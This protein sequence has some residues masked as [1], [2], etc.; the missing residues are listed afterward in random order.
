MNPRPIASHFRRQASWKLPNSRAIITLGILTTLSLPAQ[1]LR[2]A[3]ANFP[4]LRVGAAIKSTSLTSGNAIYANTVRHDFNS[5]SPENDTKWGTLRPNQTPFEW[6][7]ADAIATF[8]RAAGQQMRGHTMQWYKSNPAWLTEGGFTTTQLRDILFDHIDQVGGHYRGDVFAW[9]VVNEAFNDN[10][11][12][13]DGFW[14]ND[15]GIGYAGNGT[16]YIEETFIRAAAADPDTKLI[17]NDYGAEVTNSKSNAIYAMAQDFLTRG[18]PLD[19]IGFQMHISGINYTTLRNNF[20][21]FNDL[22]L[23][24]HITEMD[25]RVPVDANGDATPASLESQ[26]EIYWNVLG[27]ALG[28]PRFTNFQTWGLHDG[29]SWIPGWEPGS[30][31][32]LLFD[33]YYQRKPAY[34]AVWNALANQAEKFPVLDYS[35]GDSTEVQAQDTLNAGAGRKLFSNSA[36]DFMTLS[37]AVPFAGEWNVKLGYRKSSGSGQFQ[38]AVAPEG[39]GSF[40]DLGGVVDCYDPSTTTGVTD[41]GNHTFPS[42]GNWQLRFT[43]TGK[44]ASA[45]GYNHTIDTVRITPISTGTN[46]PPTVSNVTDKTTNENVSSGPFAFTIGDAQ[47]AAPALTVQAVSLNTDLLPTANITIGGSGANRT[48]TLTPAANQFGSAAV[49]LLVSDGFHTTPETFILNVTEVDDNPNWTRT[50]SGTQQWGT[51]SNWVPASVPVSGSETQIRVL[52]GISLSS[53]TV[54]VNNGLAGT[55]SLSALTLGGTGVSGAASGVTLS[56]SPLSLAT[57]PGTGAPPRIKLAAN[58]SAAANSSLVYSVANDITLANTTSLTGIGNAD[59][60]LAGIL[61]GPGGLT[62]S[63]TGLLKLT[64]ANTYAGATA[65]TAGTLQVGNNTAA[66]TLG[67]GPVTNNATLRFHRSDNTHVVPNSISGAGQL[68]FG[69]STGPAGAITEL[70]GANT[71]TGGV[72]VHSGGLRIRDSGAL[73]TGAKLIYLTGINNF[74]S[75]LILNGSSGDINLPASVSFKTSNNDATQSAIIN[76]AGNNSIAGD[77]TLTDGGGVTA[78][79]VQGGTLTLSGTFRPNTATRSLDLIGPGNGTFSGALQNDGGFVPALRKSGSG[80]WT[81]TGAAHDFTGTTTVSGGT[82]LVQSP[83]ALPAGSTVTVNNGCTLGGNGTVGGAVNLLAGAILA[84]GGISSI[85]TLALSNLGNSLSLNGN[86]LPFEISTVGNSDRINLTG[87]LVLNGANTIALSLP[88]G[89]T[90][91]GTYTLM[92]YPAR[93]GSGTLELFTSYP[94]VTLTVGANNMTLTVTSP[95]STWKGNLSGVWDTGTQNW[96]KNGNPSTYAA[97]DAV[98]FND[99]AAGNFTVSGSASPVSVTVDN[100]LNDYIISADIGGPGTSLNK[101]GAGYLTLSGTNTY[102]GTTLV[103]TGTLLVQSPGSL[104]A[105]SAVTVNNG[106]SLGGDGTINGPVT[107]QSGSTVTPGDSATVGTLALADTGAAALTLNDNPLVFDISSAVSYDRITIT[108]GL[109]LNGAGTIIVNLPGSPPPFGTYTLMTYAAITGSGTLTL[110][111]S[112]PNVTFEVGPTSVTFTVVPREATW[113]GNVDGAWDIGTPNWLKGGVTSSYAAGDIVIFDDTATGNFTVAGH[114]SPSSVTV[115][116]TANHYALTGNIG[117][118]GT[119]LTKS[120]SGM[121]TLSGANSYTGTT[122]LSGGTLEVGPV[123]NDS[124]GSGGLYFSGGVLQGNGSFTRALSGNATPGPGQTAGATGGFAAKGGQLTLNLGPTLSLN[125][126]LFRF[127]TNFIFGTATA[128]SL[129]KLTSNIDFGGGNRNITVNSGAGGDAAEFSGVVSNGGAVG[130]AFIKSGTGLLILSGDNT[131][132]GMTNIIAGTLRAAH[133][134]AFGTGSVLLGNSDATLELA[135]GITIN[136][137]LTVSNT[138]NKKSISLQNGATTGDYAGPILISETTSANFELTS[139]TGQTLTV[140]GKISGTAGAAVSKTGPGTL[141]LSGENDH[142]T[143]TIISGGV[144]IATTLADA[145][146]P[147][148]IGSASDISG[149]L[150]INGATLRHDAANIATTNRKFAVGLDGATIDS[151]AVASTDI[152]NFSTPF[153]MGFSSQ[154]GARTLTLTGSNPG[155]NTI[156]MDINDDASGNPTSLV[157]D[158]AGKW[159]ITGASNDYTGDTTVHAGTLVLADNAGLKFIITDSAANKITG[160]GTVILDGD[161]TLNTTAVTTTNGSWTLVDAGTLEEN[162]GSTFSIVGWTQAADV[163]TR[164][165]GA[166]TWKFSEATGVLELSVTGA[167]PYLSWI[168]T[169]TS[170]TVADRDPE[171]DPD[172]DGTPNLLEFALN[173]N[174][175]DILDNGLIASL[176][177]DSGGPSTNELTLI[178]AVRDGALFNAGSATVSGINYTIEGSL[179]LAFPSAAVSTTGPSDTAPATTG[180]PS[181]AGSDWEYHTFKLDASEGL[182]GRGFLRLKV[183]QP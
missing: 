48:V 137:P 75:R 157:K 106:A 140:S 84:P 173:G 3:A 83:G 57:Q 158:G 13:R 64:G 36:A 91:P 66:A 154:L 134:N 117:G 123:A 125:A 49:L 174:P 138:G 146:S 108:G 29:D 169:F 180:L 56:G 131:N 12:L 124:L 171:D 60:T 1:T 8:N 46:T 136:R 54:T 120:G 148:S 69:A 20:K 6:T 150:V 155:E 47:T 139:S 98:I 132:S 14:Y 109:V 162:F 129:V 161:F 30:G 45:V 74:K 11:T 164:I 81:I 35:I 5:P 144:L 94:N 110:S 2:E 37:L 18:V 34:W 116:N 177:Q 122:S 63:G 176:I 147:S 128:D 168:N 23:D 80:T 179:D 78:V 121:L 101:N 71:F 39:S 182:P 59:F 82:L 115:N 10:G 152:V 126:G 111:G 100:S 33:K 113:R 53:G 163:W 51:A 86:S 43:V 172:H 142:T 62:M 99:T 103:N 178:L 72:T 167:N 105:T 145:G 114:A 17:Y 58:K 76:E 40:T 119:P 135:G 102:T 50:T 166:R 79:N 133:D 104:S 70:S 41:L 31:A 97:G 87:N 38:L 170:I 112:H 160:A 67:S 153:A 52:D 143:P 65:L 183:T 159:N 151:S 25:V 127:G 68:E 26:A 141:L 19:G 85:G 175:G 96:V 130:Y 95:Q 15:P 89:P 21:R 22:G 88:A 61:S 9:D 118:T 44:N 90:P 28:Q 27:V 92:T 16:R 149:N 42:A 73:G 4:G 156:R 165:D 32:A 7:K 55:F 24:L 107:L 93:T 77:F 181:L